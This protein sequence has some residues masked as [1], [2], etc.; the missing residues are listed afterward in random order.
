MTAPDT[1]SLLA[2]RQSWRAATQRQPQKPSCF[3]HPDFTGGWRE[4]CPHWHIVGNAHLS[5][6]LVDAGGKALPWAGC[7][8]CK[9]KAAV[10]TAA[11][12]KL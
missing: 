3:D 2:V 9:H 12:L 7:A 8:G 10:A 1:P 5:R 6:A 11:P 4:G